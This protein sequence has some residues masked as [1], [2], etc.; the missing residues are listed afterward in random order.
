MA[1]FVSPGY[2]RNQLIN[3]VLSPTAERI[4][5]FQGLNLQPVIEE[6]EMSDMWNMSADNYPLLAPRKPRGEMEL[7]DDV[8][9]PLQILRRYNT[10][11]ML[12]ITDEDTI[13]FYFGGQKVTAL[14]GL[15][16]QTR[17]VA[18]NTKICFFPEKKYVEVNSIS[19]SEI[20]AVGS[21]EIDQSVTSA[22]I[23]ISDSDA[24][25]TLSTNPGLKYDD[26]IVFDGDLTFNS[27]TVKFNAS[28]AIRDVEEDT[29]IVLPKETFTSVMGDA[30]AESATF[31]GRIKR[32][33]PDISHVIEWNNRL[34]GVSDRDNTIYACKLGDPANWQYYQGTGLDSY[35]AQQGTDETWTG[36]AVYSNHLIFFKPNGMTRV[37]G[38]SPSNFQV[39]ATNCYGVE[40]GSSDS[41]L[42]INDTILYKSSIGIMAYNGSIP[43]LISDKLSRPFRNVVAGTEG[44][45]YYASCLM[46]EK[47]VLLVFD[48]SKLMWHKEDDL[49]FMSTCTIDNV[50][51]YTTI[52]HDYLACSERL[53][54]SEDLKCQS[55]FIEGGAGAINSPDPV[56]DYKD[57][58]WMALFGPFD[59]YIEEHKIYSKLAFSL[60]AN[61][62]RSSARIYVSI[63]DGPW[64]LVKLY[65]QVSTQGDYLP[66]IPRR[67]DRYSVK[68]EGSGNCAIKTLT[69]RVRQ[70]S[71]A[72]V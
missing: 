40:S 51:Y 39:T 2:K 64:E 61:D 12:A 47:R 19:G 69:R 70:G 28:T 24:R 30:A 50:L 68:I 32:T 9:R 23:S 58:E 72:R 71:L 10:L 65:S 3:N 25:L 36:A 62:N 67:C 33:I 16:V 38:T 11:A 48:M 31:T 18:I 49:R 60:K 66:V 27:T 53:K 22:S 17:A 56:E 45:K 54:C 52:K 44:R 8:K 20:V 4:I 1:V 15:S 37:Y 29:T 55:E 26:A 21:L 5:D 13:A 7:P 14:T 57:I 43:Y 6:G 42:T 46:D 41:V 63:D 34:W 59:E 35:Y